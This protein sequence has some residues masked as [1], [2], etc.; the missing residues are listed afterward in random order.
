MMK[1]SR[2][3]QVVE[4][5]RV[6]LLNGARF[7][8]A[9]PGGVVFY[10]GC[11]EEDRPDP[12]WYDGPLGRTYKQLPE[13]VVAAVLVRAGVEALEKAKELP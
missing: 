12:Y 7:E 1:W 9:G 10:M 4:S 8:V 11:A 6:R 3:R 2:Q 5:L 13:D